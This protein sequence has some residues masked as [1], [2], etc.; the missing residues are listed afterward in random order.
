VIFIVES[1]NSTEWEFNMVSGW[2][3]PA[4]RAQVPAANDNLHDDGCDACM[5][6]PYVEMQSG[7][8]PQQP[9]VIFVDLFTSGIVRVQGLIVV[10]RDGPESPHNSF[11][12]VLIFEADVLFDELKARR[13]PVVNGNVGHDRFLIFAV[14]RPKSFGGDLKL[15]RREDQPILSSYRPLASETKRLADCNAERPLP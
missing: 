12:I 3:Q 7:Q 14:R 15:A 11:Q 1:E 8:R 13:D 2:R 4:P 9:L 10:V 5:T 6:V